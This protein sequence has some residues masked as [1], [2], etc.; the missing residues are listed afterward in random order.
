MIA[1]GLEGFMMLLKPWRI[2]LKR[3]EGL[4]NHR[5]FAWGVVDSGDYD[6]RGDIFY[7][8]LRLPSYG[9][10][11]ALDSDLPAWHQRVLVF[12]CPVVGAWKESDGW[13]LIECPLP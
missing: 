12:K 5:W 8:A 9:Y 11:I 3:H 6:H 7:I 2:D 13:R 10:Q 4:S 1:T